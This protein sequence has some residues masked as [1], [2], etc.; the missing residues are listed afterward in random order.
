MTKGL[1]AACFPACTASYWKRQNS[2]LAAS[3]VER[4]HSNALCA[5]SRP[6]R[7]QRLW[8]DLLICHPHPR[9][10]F[11]AHR[12]YW[13][14]LVAFAICRLSAFLKR[15]RPCWR[16]L[17]SVAIHHPSLLEHGSG[18][19]TTVEVKQQQQEDSRSADA[20]HKVRN[21]GRG[22]IDPCIH[23]PMFC[24]PARAPSSGAPGQVPAKDLCFRV[25][26]SACLRSIIGLVPP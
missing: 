25:D 14:P 10:R 23:A 9:P 11:S 17:S 18:P 13:P 21:S 19:R 2:S 15:A 5:A 26:S 20:L 4:F 6:P 7:L 24:G 22:R 8:S 3:N 16:M 1:S 12:P